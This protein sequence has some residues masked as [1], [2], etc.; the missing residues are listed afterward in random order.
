MNIVLYDSKEGNDR[1]E[2]FI[3]T[4]FDCIYILAIAGPMAIPTKKSKAAMPKDIPAE[5]FGVYSKSIFQLPTR[6]N[7]NPI[8]LLQDLQISPVLMNEIR[9]S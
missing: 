8:A 7:V 9:I 6:V 2:P 3:E 1:V 5:S 4:R